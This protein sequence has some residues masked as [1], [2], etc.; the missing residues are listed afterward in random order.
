MC[1]EIAVIRV[2]ASFIEQAKDECEGREN[3]QICGW[4]FR[5]G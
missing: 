2:R 3:S 5:A 4:R 1:L